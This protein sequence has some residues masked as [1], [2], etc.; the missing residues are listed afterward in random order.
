MYF[1]RRGP[2][3]TYF[4]FKKQS[5]LQPYTQPEQEANHFFILQKPCWMR[6]F[7]GLKGPKLVNMA[8]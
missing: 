4:L 2:A 5:I 6:V 1:G 7:G 3:K 8:W